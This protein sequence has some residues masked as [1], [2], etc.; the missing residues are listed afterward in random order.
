[1]SPYLPSLQYPASEVQ[2]FF[3]CVHLQYLT[4]RPSYSQ[5]LSKKRKRKKNL[6]HKQNLKSVLFT[7]SESVLIVCNEFL[8][9]LATFKV[10]SYTYTGSMYY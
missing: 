1:M 10:F 3:P 7:E 5:L 4:L 9:I 2:P 6:I 8:L